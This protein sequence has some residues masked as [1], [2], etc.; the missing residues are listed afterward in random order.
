M[1]DPLKLND[2]TST[3][4]Q[5]EN[6]TRLAGDIDA[7]PTKAWMITNRNNPKYARHWASDWTPPPEEFY[8]L[9]SDPHQISNLADNKAYDA[10]A[11]ACRLF[12]WTS[13]SQHIRLN[14]D[15]FDQ[16]P[17]NKTRPGQTR[18]QY[19]VHSLTCPCK[20]AGSFLEHIHS[21]SS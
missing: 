3:Y 13:L 17:Y 19:E 14:G 11:R 4:Q 18:R 12:W 6:S 10:V 9:T 8:D 2:Q 20:G 15:T 16:P 1:G 21:H 5:L 7:G